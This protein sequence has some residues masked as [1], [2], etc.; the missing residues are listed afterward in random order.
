MYMYEPCTPGSLLPLEVNTFVSGGRLGD[1]YPVGGDEVNVLYHL[2]LVDE[3]TNNMDTIVTNQ[4]SLL[5]GVLNS[6]VDLNCQVCTCYKV[7][8]VFA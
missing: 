8:G 4:T 6:E 5:V 1:E 3:T 7:E 2:T